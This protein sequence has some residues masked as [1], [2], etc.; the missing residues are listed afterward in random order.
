M[1][2]TR[3]LLG[4]EPMKRIPAETYRK[5]GRVVNDIPCCEEDRN[6]VWVDSRQD[7]DMESSAEDGIRN[8][9]QSGRQGTSLGEADG[10]GVG[11]KGIAKRGKELKVFVQYK[12]SSPYRVG[13][14]SHFCTELDIRQHT[15]QDFE[16]EI[17]FVS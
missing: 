8:R 9:F 2:I 14:M 10:T 5:A 4:I 6:H 7:D 16:P 12:G 17:F 11:M 13:K 3:K 1:Y 15:G